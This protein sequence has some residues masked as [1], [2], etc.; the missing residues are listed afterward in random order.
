MDTSTTGMTAAR[1]PWGPIENTDTPVRVLNRL[2]EV[3]DARRP[4]C[5]TDTLKASDARCLSKMSDKWWISSPNVDVVPQFPIHDPGQVFKLCAD[6]MLGPF[7]LWKW[8][9]LYDESLPHGMASPA[10]PDVLKCDDDQ[11]V[12]PAFK[13]LQVA[14]WH[15]DSRD[16]V[17]C[18]DIPGAA[19]GQLQSGVLSRLRDA[20]AEVA[21]MVHNLDAKHNVDQPLD[22]ELVRNK[23]RGSSRY[24][25]QLIGKLSSALARLEEIPMTTF[26]IAQW[27][28]EVQRLLLEARAWCIYTDVVVPRLA[29]P[30]TSHANNVLP[31]RGVFTGRLSVAERLF[32]CGIPVWWIRPAHTLTNRTTIMRVHPVLPPSVHFNMREEMKHGRHTM[33]APSWLKSSTFDNVSESIADQLRPYSLSGR[34]TLRKVEAVWLEDSNVTGHHEQDIEPLAVCVGG[35]SELRI[36][37]EDVS[38]R[39]HR[40]APVENLQ[41]GKPPAFAVALAPPAPIQKPVA[42]RGHGEYDFPLSVMQAMDEVSSGVAKRR[43]TQSTAVS[44]WRQPSMLPGHPS[45]NPVTRILPVAQPSMGWVDV[46]PAQ[47]HHSSQTTSPRPQLY[48]LPPAHLFYSEGSLIGE[49]FHNWLRIR[50]YCL[51]QATDPP[52]DGRVLM[53]TN[54]W[55]M[56][57]EGKYYALPY[58]SL[59][60]QPVSLPTDIARLPSNPDVDPSTLKRTR[61]LE[62]GETHE[63]CSSGERRRFKRIADRIDV[64]VRF[65]VHARFTPYQAALTMPSWGQLNVTRAVAD[66]DRTLWGEVVWELT[67]MNFRLE[68]LDVDQDLLPALYA[69]EDTSHAARRQNDLKHIW[70]PHGYLRPM[71]CT[72]RTD[73]LGAMDW[74]VRRHAFVQWARAMEGWPSAC[75]QC[76]E[77]DLQ[78]RD[79]YDAFEC[80]VVEFYCRAFYQQRARLPTVPLVCP[81]SMVRHIIHEG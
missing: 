43:K 39:S 79:H 61:E 4:M 45:S 67:V 66:M 24:V 71:W 27:F 55:R 63:A 29:D 51:A 34:P 40:G 62:D 44:N 72:C 21:E 18:A 33:V 42:R 78:A 70:S 50:M 41:S 5:P 56:A 12:L 47:T 77:E 52:A 20:L 32:R 64:N 14:W 76:N 81:P 31:L 53:T 15:F 68:F 1:P 74:T 38:G 57:L 8:P 26:D 80:K 6:A 49:R 13:D 60:V 28:R 23:H 7:E 75:L 9:Q 58:R 10:N 65:G 54:Q 17:P 3:M 37:Q 59:V 36:E 46:S 22:S 16:F 25:W 30:L 35:S 11:R 48:S 2:S 73:E 19:I 69:E